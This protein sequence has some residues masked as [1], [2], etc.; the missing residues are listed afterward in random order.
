[1]HRENN[2][3]KTTPSQ[4]GTPSEPIHIPTHESTDTRLA[5]LE[6]ALHDMSSRLQR[7]EDYSQYLQSRHQATLDSTSRL[8]Y[9][10]QELSRAILSIIPPDSMAHREGTFGIVMMWCEVT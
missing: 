9:I 1:V 10:N 5:N 4:P 6:Y 3:A 2:F 7:S 8:C